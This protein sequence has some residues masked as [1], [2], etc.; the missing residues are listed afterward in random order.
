MRSELVVY[1]LGAETQEIVLR[2][3]HHI[4]APNWMPGDAALLVNSNGRL[5]RVPLADPA[6]EAVDTGFATGL[7]NDHGISP[8]GTRIAISDKTETGQSCIY[9]IPIGGGAPERVTAEVPSYFHGWSP[10]GAQLAY[11]GFRG[12]EAEIFTCP[13]AGGPE[14]QITFD[15]DHCDGPD[16]TPDG[17]WIWF[18]GEMDGA[19]DLWRVRPDGTGLERMTSDDSVNWFPHPSPDGKH[20][21]YLAY[22]PGTEGH[23]ADL[24]VSLRLMPA[25]GGD[26]REV[27]P[28]FGGQGTINVPCWASDARRFAF[29]R[30]GQ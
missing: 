30:Y 22:P 27:L 15:F 20:V 8:D 6:L 16:Y 5:F 9:T 4:E 7:N 2:S 17:A 12:A 3:E 28:L 23:P 25:E 13:A 1:D 11:A 29:V 21:L 19:V 24:D 10:D 18:N 14:R 26:S